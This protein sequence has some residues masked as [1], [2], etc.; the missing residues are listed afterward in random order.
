MQYI[1]RICRMVGGMPL[2]IILAATWVEHL[3]PATIATELTRGFDLLETELRDLPE[4]QRSMRTI[5]DYSVAAAH[6]KGT[7]C[8]YAVGHISG[9]LYPRAAQAVAGA[10]LPIL[11]HLVD[12]SFLQSIAGER[13]EIHELLRQYAGQQLKKVEALTE[14][15]RIHANYYLDLLHN[16]EERLAGTEQLPVIHQIEAD[17]ENI[18]AAWQ[19]AVMQDEY[20]LID[21][22]LEGLFRWFW[23]RRGRQQEGLAL[24]NMAHQRLTPDGSKEMRSLWGR[25]AVRMV[26]QQG[27]WFVEPTTVRDRTERALRIA[28]EQEDEAEIA[29]CHWVIGLT[30][31]SEGRMLE[32]AAIKPANFHYERAIS[33]YRTMDER[34]W[35]AHALEFQGHNFRQLEEY[36]RANRILEESLTQRRIQNDRFGMARSYREI[37]WVRFFQGLEVDTI[38]AAET[39]LAMQLEFGDQQGIADGQFFLALSLLCCGDWQR[40]KALNTPV[41]LFATDVNNLL[42]KRWSAYITTIVTAMERHMRDRGLSGCAFPNRFTPFSPKLF[43]TIFSVEE[44]DI[45]S[46]QIS[47]RRNVRKIA[48]VAANE[49][50]KI[51]ALQFA[52]ILWVHMG[53]HYRALQL[54][55]LVASHSSIVDSWVSYLPKVMTLEPTL[56]KQ[57]APT[58]FAQAWIEGQAL[59][60]ETVIGELCCG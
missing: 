8:F 1:A 25:I 5:L 51:V 40:A 48:Q 20:R 45:Y 15:Q 6:C 35:L 53:N 55:A 52:A 34:F 27:P 17:F 56:R 54:L 3:A 13:Y 10:T 19:W 12:K 28:E 38:Q 50:E 31:V 60:L 57:L 24:L 26:E 33:L 42:Y 41:Q 23:L 11:V 47:L 9:R 14:T 43:A 32:R 21:G 2:G 39:A 29:F 22:A 4:R 30:I 59:A 49:A 58:A 44:S 18:R 16:A 37:A 36:E 7:R 46:H